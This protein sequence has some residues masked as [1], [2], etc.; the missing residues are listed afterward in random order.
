MRDIMM[1]IV[2]GAGGIYERLLL[3]LLL[4]LAS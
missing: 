3:H 4:R 1:A 2:G